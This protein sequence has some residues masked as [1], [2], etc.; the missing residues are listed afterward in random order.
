[1]AF[2]PDIRFPA[3]GLDIGDR[4]LKLVDLRKKGKKVILRSFGRVAVPEGY[5][6]K[7]EPKESQKIVDLIRTLIKKV[8][9]R[10]VRSNYVVSVLP[11][12]KAFI[13]L[14]DRLNLDLS[15]NEII[16]AIKG[17]IKYQIPLDLEEAY[18]DWQKIESDKILVAVAPIKIVE[19]YSKL[20]KKAGLI[21]LALEVESA[22][23]VRA[24]VKE[25]IK[26]TT[27]VFIDIGATRSSIIFYNK[28]VIRFTASM[29][30]SGRAMDEA[31]VRGKKLSLDQAEKIKIKHGLEKDILGSIMDD[32]VKK[33]Q[34]SLDYY[35]EHFSGGDKAF[36]VR[37]CGGGAYTLGLEKFLS[38]KLHLDVKKADSLVNI[39]LPGKKALFPKDK[40]LLY[41][42]AIG[43]ALRGELIEK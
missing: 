24:L 37:L 4:S 35:A 20:L 16:P 7:G 27:Q 33:I 1:M 41:T 29:P 26:G 36:R 30:V 43:L 39:T 10:K 22:A 2:F 38:E 31:I 23:I 6:D 19:D 40:S 25:E 5:F 3:F 21:P 14:I 17:K 42:T 18:L 34:G 12:T 11:E 32:L 15:K 13:T 28:G 9:G 8:G